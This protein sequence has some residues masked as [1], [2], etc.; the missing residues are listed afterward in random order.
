MSRRGKG[1]GSIFQREDGKWIATLDITEGR[2]RRKR[3][4]KICATRTAAKAALQDLQLR[5]KRLGKDT[6][7][8][9]W[10]THWLENPASQRR[11]STQRS[12]S[13]TV[14]DHIRPYLQHYKVADLTVMTLQRWLGELTEQNRTP[15]VVQMARAVL[16]AALTEAV[17]VDLIATNP[18]MPVRVPKTRQRRIRPA[19]PAELD[20]LASAGPPWFA[21]WLYVTVTLGLRRG[22]SLGLQWDDLDWQAGTLTIAR[23]V[24]DCGIIGVP[25]TESS[26]RTYPVPSVVLTA[27]QHHRRRVELAA[28]YDRREVGAWIFAS[29]DGADTPI[30]PRTL[31]R[32]FYAARRAANLPS[33]FRIHDLRHTTGSLMLNQ[34]TDPKT[35]AAWLGHADVRTTLRIYTQSNPHL[36]LVA[37]ARLQQTLKP[38]S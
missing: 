35:I 23:T 18:A 30:G 2:G 8:G 19:T 16:R 34:G 36:Q 21:T 38:G 28:M 33:D 15:R 22:E 12:Y 26:R 32:A 29:R 37:G 25:K 11:D 10:L 1:D 13:Q 3:I 4:K 7:V 17:R 27:L 9:A 14:R 5:A 6:T 20:R 31:N 24:L